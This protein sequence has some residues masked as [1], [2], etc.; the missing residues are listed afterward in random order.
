MMNLWTWPKSNCHAERPWWIKM[1]PRCLR[2]LVLVLTIVAGL[3]LGQRVAHILLPTWLGYSYVGSSTSVLRL[4]CTERNL[5]PVPQGVV[6]RTTFPIRNAGNRRL[7]LVEQTEGCCGQSVDPHQVILAPGDWKYLTVE[8][9][10]AQW[11]G[12]LQ[13]TVRYTTNDPKLPR[14][15]L[16]VNAIVQSALPR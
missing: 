13:H 1:A 6:L 11:H 10:T 12:R 9:D 5:G 14:F 4:L 8:V 16:K 3:L 15:A 7:I 2:R